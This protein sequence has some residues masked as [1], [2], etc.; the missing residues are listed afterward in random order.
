[1]ARAARGG[2]LAAREG[3]AVRPVRAV[4]GVEALRPDDVGEAQACRRSAIRS[5]C[6][7]PRSGSWAVC[8]SGSSRIAAGISP[9]A[10]NGA[11]AWPW[12]AEHGIDTPEPPERLYGA[13]RVT[14][15]SRRDGDKRDAGAVLE[16]GR[17]EQ[18]L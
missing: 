7:S 14:V 3:R 4:E 5:P 8:F 18:A 10:Y 6:G 12:P 2:E 13:R 9:S 15:A 1:V 11:G 16:S 17:P